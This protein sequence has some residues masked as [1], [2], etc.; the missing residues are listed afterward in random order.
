MKHS[1][2]CPHECGGCKSP[3][4]LDEFFKGYCLMCAGNRQHNAYSCDNCWLKLSVDEKT[5]AMIAA[6]KYYK[7]QTKGW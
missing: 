4:F 2:N 7:E 3:Y 6:D 5:Q 1:R